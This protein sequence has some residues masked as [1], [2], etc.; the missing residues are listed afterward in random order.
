MGGKIAYEWTK[1]IMSEGLPMPEMLFISGCRPPHIPEPNPLHNLDDSAFI[2]ALNRF[3]PR[4][5]AV[6]AHQEMKA[7]L[8]PLLRND[9]I[10]DEQYCLQNSYESIPIPIPICALCGNKDAEAPEKAMLEWEK[11]TDKNFSL[12]LCDGGHFFV[13]ENQDQVIGHILSAIN[14]R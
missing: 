1:K 2:D 6:L 4:T 8:M 3:S 14:N 9:F 5:A 13:Y 10:L 7:L 11:Y 12:S